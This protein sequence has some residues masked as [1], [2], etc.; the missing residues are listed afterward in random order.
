MNVVS[1]FC[2]V[3]TRLAVDRRLEGVC[4]GAPHKSDCKSSC[5]D[6]AVAITQ[7]GPPGLGGDA[8]RP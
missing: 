6:A 5:A 4:K 3:S 1:A 7:Y 2:H 8:L